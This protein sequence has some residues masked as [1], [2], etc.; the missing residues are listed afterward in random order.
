MELVGKYICNKLC[1]DNTKGIFISEMDEW[2]FVKT[3]ICLLS[4]MMRGCNLLIILCVMID[5]AS[6]V[7][8]KLMGL[9]SNTSYMSL[10]KYYLITYVI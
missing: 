6:R 8:V 9:P 5:M 4:G 10:F 2:L 3:T 1:H 7:P